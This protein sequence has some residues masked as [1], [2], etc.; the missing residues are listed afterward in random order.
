MLH[1]PRQLLKQ[2]LTNATGLQEEWARQPQWFNLYGVVS[3]IVVQEFA[4]NR[5]STGL[6]PL[7]GPE[8]VVSWENLRSIAFR[9]DDQPLGFSLTPFLDKSMSGSYNTIWIHL[10][11]ERSFTSYVSLRTAGLQGTRVLTPRWCKIEEIW[12]CAEVAFLC[13]YSYQML[14]GL[15]WCMMEIPMNG[16]NPY[17]FFEKGTDEIW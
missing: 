15:V 1:V 3:Q 11:N 13:G 16:L 6:V 14:Y 7:F 17:S 4:K 5:R 2:L 12:V 9:S 10:G 8:S